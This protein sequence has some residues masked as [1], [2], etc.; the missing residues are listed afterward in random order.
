MKKV[1]LV[2]SLLALTGLFA[3]NGGDEEMK[4]D[5]S[6]ALAKIENLQKKLKTKEDQ[7]DDLQNENIRLNQQVI[8]LTGAKEM[9]AVEVTNI[10]WE[11]NDRDFQ[12]ILH[13]TIKNTGRAYL[14]N[15]TVKVEIMDKFDNV[16]QAPVVND[17]D[18]E[19]MPMLFFHDVAE[20]LNMGDSKT[21]KMIIY[22]RN[23][24]ASGLGKVKEAIDNK[25]QYKVT[26]LFV[27]AK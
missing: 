17:P 6:E 11:E 9:G 21:F 27:T 1:M 24:H 13:G 25:D 22:T 3:C 7:S 4:E 19:I 18:R 16:I 23:I 12:L 10:K 5:L 14:S 8:E 2:L 26:G 15:I 20:A